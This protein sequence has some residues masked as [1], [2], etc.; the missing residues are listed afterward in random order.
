MER[1]PAIATL[2]AAAAL[3]S[4]A[5][6]EDSFHLGGAV[7]INHVWLDYGPGKGEGNTDLELLRVD[8][9]ARRGA[10]SYSLQYRFYNDFEGV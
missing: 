10:F 2:L 9:R 5:N 7:R 3:G 1:W 8:S 6:A 4:P